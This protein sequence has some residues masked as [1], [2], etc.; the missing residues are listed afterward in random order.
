[1][2]C[3]RDETGWD[4]AAPSLTLPVCEGR[5]F[6]ISCRLAREQKQRA[7]PLAKGEVKS[8]EVETLDKVG[9]GGVF[10]PQPT[11]YFLVSFCRERTSRGGLSRLPVWVHET[12]PTKMSPLELMQTP[13]GA[14]KL[15][16]FSLSAM[17]PSLAR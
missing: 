3:G 16:G 8:D 1:M 6:S 15:P 9:D 13:W 2:S 12:S 14:M 7:F 11:N 4:A 17:S 10:P 5:E